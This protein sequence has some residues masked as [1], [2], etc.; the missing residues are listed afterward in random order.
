MAGKMI[1]LKI[2][3]IDVQVEA[4][5]T[6]LEAARKVGIRIPTLCYL[7]D[8]NAIGACRVCVVEV[9]GARSLVAS[10]VYPVSEGMEVTT[11]SPRV[12]NSR[13]KTVE[14]LLSDHDKKCLSC[15][16]SGNCELQTLANE[17]GC[18]D[19]KFKGEVNNFELDEST[20]YL[21]RDNNKCILCRRCVAACKQYQSVAVIGANARGFK[22]NIGSE[23]SKPL[24]EIACVG[25]GQCI[26]VCPTGALRER[27]EID[28]VFAAINDPSKVVIVGTA[29]SVRV[30]LG[31]EFGNPIGTN[32]EGKMVAA[33][34]KLG[35]DWVFD[36]NVTA[37]LTILE[38]GTEFIGRVLN[39]GKLPMITSC[40]PG[41]IKYIEHYYPDYLAH[42]SSCKSPQ[43]M[44][45][46]VC[47]TYFAEKMG[48]DPKNII[49]V[50]IM[51]CTAKK[52]EKTRPY[53]DAAG[54]GIQDVDYALTSRELAR[55][56]KRQGI[57]FNELKDEEF[58]APMGIASGAGLI[59]GAT[60]GVMEAALR[61]VYEVLEKKEL[62]NLDF[63]AVRGT[64]G[65]KEA[66]IPVHV[67]GKL[68]DVKVAAVSGLANA[69]I[70][71]EKIKNGEADYHFI[72]VMAC[73]GGCVNGG[74]QP[75]QPADV[76]NN[77]DIRKIR[78]A[79]LYETDKSMA[80]RKS[81]ESPV[82]K[83]LYDT[84]FGEPGSEK[85]HHILHTKYVAR[86]K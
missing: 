56:I 54:K 33:L 73:P 48:L 84:Y 80:L 63:E 77:V 39:G 10:C 44:F 46:A 26:N 21:V 68:V 13:K 62:K 66:V 74:G 50:S 45:G 51:P 42:L 4:G 18:D 6:I 23:F 7:K 24:M 28:E 65:I 61:T 64:E 60:G 75:I 9:K 79:M 8:I 83:E 30:G 22:T 59:F 49:V 27:D 40:S 82:V 43:Q 1:N 36:V 25:C 5:T 32:V 76:R 70:I 2:N 58:D 86:G 31:E 52:F 11:N 17:F 41:W 35:F 12:L 47:K 53:Q 78:A 19:V 3:G 55:F 14:L 72:E 34:K 20:P 29:P 67:N 37:D 38:E 71:M 57:M 15:V 81:H 16:R 85:S 69:K